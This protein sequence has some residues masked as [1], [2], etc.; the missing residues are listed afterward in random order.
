MESVNITGIAMSLIFLSAVTEH[1]IS[2]LNE[3]SELESNLISVERLSNFEK[4]ESET[5]YVN[6]EQEEKK[7]IVLGKENF[8]KQLDKF[9][10]WKFA[11]PLILPNP[12]IIKEGK[13]TFTNVSARY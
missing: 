7:M 5:G 11:P 12:T 9:A 8:D 4:I 2:T 13:I 1:T 10:Y 3:M 6:F